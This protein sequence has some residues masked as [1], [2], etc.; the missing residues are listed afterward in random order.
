MIEILE[1]ESD[2]W[3]V[4]YKQRTKGYEYLIVSGKSPINWG[5]KPFIPS[6]LVKGKWTRGIEEFF[7]EEG[8]EIDYEERGYWD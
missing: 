4:E 2:P 1:G 6:G 5:G 8:I 7:K 3:S